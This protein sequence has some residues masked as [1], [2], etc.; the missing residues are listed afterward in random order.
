[1]WPKSDER[2]LRAFLRNAQQDP[3][4][5]TLRARL[6]ADVDRRFMGLVTRRVCVPRYALAGAAV[7]IMALL[8]GVLLTTP[9]SPDVLAAVLGA[10]ENVRTMHI[11][12][13]REEAWVSREHG[14]RFEHGRHV[15]LYTPEAT[16]G[17]D[18]ETNKVVI[19]D[20][21][22]FDVVEHV[23]REYSGTHWL[24][25][26]R[27]DPRYQLR[28]FD[29]FADG[30]SLKRI[31]IQRPQRQEER[32]ARP[33]GATLWIDNDTMRVVLAVYWGLNEEGRIV[34]EAHR[35]ECDV[36]IDPALFTLQVPPGAT[37]IDYRRDPALLA[38]IEEAA[39]ALKSGWVHEVV[40]NVLL[41]EEEEPDANRWR[42]WEAWRQGG[43]GYRIEYADG[44]IRVGNRGDAWCYS[45]GDR[46]CRRYQYDD[47]TTRPDEYE[48]LVGMLK[49]WPDKIDRNE[50]TYEERDGRRFAHVVVWVPPAG[51]YGQRHTFET[52]TTYTFDLDK[53]R[54]TQHEHYRG[55]GSEWLWK[56][57]TQLDYHEE[58]PDGIFSFNP[59]PGAR[60]EEGL[61]ERWEGRD[62]TLPRREGEGAALQH[63]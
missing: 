56:R 11:V 12:G 25:P 7:L 59:P 42:E 13:T 57:R 8:I 27:H 62:V 54:L 16:W 36:T 22:R 39:E 48:R 33:S 49:G 43:V 31:D 40:E 58:L 24:G 4:P 53:K 14:M 2:K 50:V 5:E 46:K 6:Q 17:Y 18:G 9:R 23:L 51:L 30:M 60:I 41:A 26:R 34:I 3:V 55:D 1:M 32:H 37:V 20:P 61:R 47:A 38:V 19:D 10:M 15:E 29:V 44:E 21:E 45:P 35:I 28:V 52:K 63:H